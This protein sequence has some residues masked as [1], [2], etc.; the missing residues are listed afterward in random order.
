MPDKLL[1]DHVS[2][3]LARVRAAADGAT[4][5]RLLCQLALYDL[6]VPLLRDARTRWASG[7]PD[8][9]RACTEKLGFNMYEVRD[10]AGAAWRGGVV[11]CEGSPWLVH[12]DDHDA[13]HRHAPAAVKLLHRQ[14]KL[15]P[16]PL[17]FK[18]KADDDSNL[19]EKAE[20]VTLLRALLAALHVATTTRRAAPVSTKY[21]R[22]ATAVLTVHV[23]DVPA[24]GWETEEAHN[25]AD[26]VSL[27]LSLRAVDN[28]VLKWVIATCL[29]FLQP[30]SSQV[31]SFYDASLTS[32]IMMSR[33]RLVQLLA[34][35]DTI[36]VQRSSSQVTQAPAVRHYVDKASMT[37]AF[38]YGFAVRAVC[39]QWWVPAGDGEHYPE[40]PICSD[41]E[42]ELPAAQALRTL[43]NEAP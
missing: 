13:F 28:A 42:T 34:D 14:G 37:A 29:P 21:T 1:P 38:V 7:Q 8:L 31:E 5:Y 3:I 26:I 41:C 39:G 35:P 43:L 18:L 9:H 17:D 12:A 32:V 24:D 2:A 4:K 20:Q 10:R 11:M 23:N 36:T 25:F 40:L 6:D 16:G 33:A 22:A 30:D 27:S 15:L 19:A